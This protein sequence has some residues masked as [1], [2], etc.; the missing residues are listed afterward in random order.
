MP[1]FVFEEGKNVSWVGSVVGRKEGM[2]NEKWDL[3]GIM[4]WREREKQAPQTME[5]SRTVVERGKVGR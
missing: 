4:I 5:G 1:V 2:G 3:D